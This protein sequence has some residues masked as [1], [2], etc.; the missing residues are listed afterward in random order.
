MQATDQTGKIWEH[1]PNVPEANDDAATLAA[2][3]VD[4][5]ADLPNL[6]AQAESQRAQNSL[7]LTAEHQTQAE[8]DKATI[9]LLM[10]IQDSLEFSQTL[11][12]FRDFEVRAGANTNARA[13][14]LGVAR[15]DYGLVATRYNQI[16]GIATGL[17]ND[18]ARVWEIGRVW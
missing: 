15:A 11:Q 13:A 6:E 14:Y 17:A 9:S 2:W 7:G 10:Q 16:T 12:W 8:L 4:L 3:V 1:R 5:D 18:A